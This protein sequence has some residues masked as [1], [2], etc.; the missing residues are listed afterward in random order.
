M[1]LISHCDGSLPSVVKF[2]GRSEWMNPYGYLP[3]RLWGYLS[4]YSVM[5]FVFLG[6]AFVWFLLH[7]HYWKDI[8][9]VQSAITFVLFLCMAEAMTW[10]FDYRNFNITGVRNIGPVV[11]AVLLGVVRKAVSRLLVVSVALGW[12]IVKYVLSYLLLRAE[13]VAYLS[14]CERCPMYRCPLHV[15]FLCM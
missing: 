3:G 6:A 5:S 11:W 2:E 9:A 14:V 8:L 4:F 12:G 13:S 7:V 15:F 1:L 10:Y